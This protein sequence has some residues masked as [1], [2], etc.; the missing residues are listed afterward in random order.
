MAR[1]INIWLVNIMDKARKLAVKPDRVNF[2]VFNCQ[3]APTKKDVK[4]AVAEK[5]QQLKTL[6]NIKMRKLNHSINK[7][8]ASG[9][10][11]LKYSKLKM[12]VT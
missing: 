12:Y 10:R 1:R 7:P 9:F 8:F 3:L 4:A 6:M 2:R 5:Q 11:V